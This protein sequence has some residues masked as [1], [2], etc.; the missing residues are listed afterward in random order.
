L[1]E[2]ARLEKEQ[3]EQRRKQEEKKL[4]KEAEA[5]ELQRLKE[6]EER[7][8]KL[9]QEEE[10]IL[11]AKQEEALRLAQERERAKEEKERKEKEEREEQERLSKLAEETRLRLEEATAKAK[12]EANSEPKPDEREE[13]ELEAHKGDGKQDGQLEDGKDVDTE[14]LKTMEDDK[15][16]LKDNL[17]I[18]TTSI[19]SPTSDKRRPGPLDLTSATRSA[20]PVVAA[21]ATARVIADIATVSYSEGYHSPHPDLNQNVKNGKFRY[22]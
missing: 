9:K 18:N 19:H 17:R 11:K 15:D 20:S 7:R 14:T 1:E 13:A 8:L 2:A 10:R 4:R 16:K 3:K 22:H 12:A 5:L 21:L 6:E